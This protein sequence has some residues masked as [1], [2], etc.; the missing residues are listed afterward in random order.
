MS[1]AAL[2][3]STTAQASPAMT[4]RPGSGTSTNT[5]SPSA[6][7]AWSEMPTVTLP[8]DSSRA[9]SWDLRY[10]RSA[11]TLL[12]TSSAPASERNCNLAI[13]HERRPDDRRAEQPSADLDLAALRG[14][15]RH[16]RKTDGT[17]QGRR[18]APAG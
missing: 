11:G 17:F 16:P 3:D 15:H 10:R 5:R 13:A 4:R 6:C 8:S 14:L 1:E 2:T 7:C 12:M 9:H 18:E